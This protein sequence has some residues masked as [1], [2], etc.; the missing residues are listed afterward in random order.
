MDVNSYV[1][2]QSETINALKAKVLELRLQLD[3]ID[4]EMMALLSKRAELI[5][6]V[7]NL[8]R[9][10]NI[11]VHIP[12]RETA[13]MQRLRL[14]N[15]GPLKGDAI[16][17]IFRTIIESGTPGRSASGGSLRSGKDIF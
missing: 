2:T 9:D 12:E 15:D 7:A 17:H 11:P 4:N 1:A 16:E 13:I 8:K 10:E 5:V 14:A 3:A 6:R